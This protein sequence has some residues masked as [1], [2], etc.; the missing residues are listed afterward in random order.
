M[1]GEDGKTKVIG[2][3]SEVTPVNLG[4]WQKYEIIC[5]GNRLIHKLNGKVTVDIEDNHPE[6][7]LKGMIGMQLHV[8]GPM[9]CWFRNIQLKRCNVYLRSSPKPHTMVVW[10]T[11]ILAHL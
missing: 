3:T 4:E 10:A 8:G 1:V 6:R 2:K 7:L 5:K 11:F 9:E